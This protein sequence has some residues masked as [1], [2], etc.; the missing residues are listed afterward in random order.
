MTQIRNHPAFRGLPK[1]AWRRIVPICLHEDAGPHTKSS[2]VNIIH[3]S[4]LFGKGGVHVSLFPMVTYIKE[5]LTTLQLEALWR[6]L[7]ADL[8]VLAHTGVGGYKFLASVR[9]GRR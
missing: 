6:P 1:D 3:F 9:E 2:Q 8:D 4:G 5:K 7:L